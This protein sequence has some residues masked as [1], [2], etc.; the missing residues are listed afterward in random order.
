LNAK[1]DFVMEPPHNDT[2][3]S[4]PAEAAEPQAKHDA[5]LERDLILL[6]FKL[7]EAR[8]YLVQPTIRRQP[9]LALRAGLAMVNEVRV[10]TAVRV[11]EDPDPNADTPLTQAEQWVTSAQALHHEFR[12][13]AKQ[14]LFGFFGRPAARNSL[15]LDAFQR[16]MH[17]LPPVLENLLGLW[18]RHFRTPAAGREWVQASLLFLDDLSQG[19]SADIR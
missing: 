18:E 6:L 9:A 17:D 5:S 19:I 3:L 1:R 4:T 14:S 13:S 11:A 10:F 15:H 8:A 12:P 7:D 2:A 16:V